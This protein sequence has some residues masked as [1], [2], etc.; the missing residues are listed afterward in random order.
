MRHRTDPARRSF[1]SRNHPCA[2]TAIT[3]F[4]VVL[5]LAIF[6]GAFAAIGQVLRTGTRSAT[7]AQLTS[8]AVLRCER[9][10]NDI[11]AGVLPMQ[12]ASNVPFEDDDQWVYSINVLDSGTANLLI[13]E[14]VVE[15]QGT[16]GDSSVAYRLTRMMRDPQMY[17]D[18]AAGT[19]EE[20]L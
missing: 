17:L 10:M 5:A 12:S 9:V 15:R 7:R 16:R 8:N 18:A 20:L 19:S 4:E 2:R 3:L 1:P 13:V 6:L 14:T 11:L